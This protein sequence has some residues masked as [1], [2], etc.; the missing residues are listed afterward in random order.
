MTYLDTVYADNLDITKPENR[1]VYLCCVVNLPFR[2][3]VGDSYAFPESNNKDFKLYFRNPYKNPPGGIDTEI[4]A[5]QASKQGT[6]NFFWT[7]VL[8]VL[9]KQR[10]SSRTL[11]VLNDFIIAYGTI[12]KSIGSFLEEVKTL[13]H[14]EFSEAQEWEIHYHCPKGYTLTDSDVDKLLNHRSRLTCSGITCIPL[15]KFTDLSAQALDKIPATFNRHQE[16][17]FYEFAFYAKVRMESEDHIGALL[18]ACIA[19]E[20]AHGTFLRQVREKGLSTCER[21]K[22]RNLKKEL[23]KVSRGS[24][25]YQ[26]I[27]T[28]VSVLMDSNE[29]PPNELLGRCKKAIEIRNDI[30]HA[31]Y[32]KGTYKLRKYQSS[33]LVDAYKALLDTYQY[34]VT[35]LEKRQEQ[36]QS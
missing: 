33:Q 15:Y 25:L 12:C 17:V 29:S 31:K 14:M 30:M 34:F 11:T 35:A 1:E 22:E 10:N 3:R 23:K 2:L 27:K 19:L 16:Y 8:I 5:K 18:M 24:Q 26:H 7:K 21:K 4:L 28:T 36:N 6:Y 9:K 20:A 13:N 32:H